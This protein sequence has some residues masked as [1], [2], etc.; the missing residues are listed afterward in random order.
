M[1]IQWALMPPLTGL[2][3]LGIE[4]PEYVYVCV[5]IFF[6]VPI[7]YDPKNDYMAVSAEC[8]AAIVALG[9]H[10]AASDWRG[11]KYETVLGGGLHECLHP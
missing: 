6:L 2:E 9:G 3:V 10:L 7:P 4:E 1:K 8:Y 5:P 11:Q